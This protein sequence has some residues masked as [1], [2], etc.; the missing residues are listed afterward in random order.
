MT[1]LCRRDVLTLRMNPF[2][3][4]RSANWY[5][6]LKTHDPGFEPKT[7]DQLIGYGFKHSIAIQYLENRNPFW[8]SRR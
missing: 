7:V 5:S 3:T 8:F 6:A 2:L 4:A 1:I